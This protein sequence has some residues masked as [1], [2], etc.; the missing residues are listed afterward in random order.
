MR[1]FI[2]IRFHQETGSRLLELRDELRTITER[3]RFTEPENLHLTLV[4]LGECDSQQAAAARSAMDQIQFAA[5]PIQIDRIGRFQRDRGNVWWAGVGESQPLLELQQKLAEALTL[6][7]F[8]LEKTRYSPHI[9]LGRKVMAAIPPWTIEPFG[10]M[11]CQIDLMVSEQ[12]GGKLTYSP[13]YEKRCG[14]SGL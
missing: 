9:T 8:V 2:A 7:G 11:V 1:L 10:E 13:I 5:F 6:A 14:D 12:I 3:G 4:F